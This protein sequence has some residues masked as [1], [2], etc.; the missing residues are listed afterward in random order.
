MK[1][2]TSVPASKTCF[3]CHQDKHILWKNKK[4]QHNPVNLGDCT[5]CHNPHGLDKTFFMRE[6]VYDLCGDCH[7]EKLINGHIETTFYSGKAHPI[8]EFDDPL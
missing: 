6:S 1:Y 5:K 3:L 8:R 2:L 4:F 7:R